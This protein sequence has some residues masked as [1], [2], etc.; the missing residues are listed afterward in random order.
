MTEN[1]NPSTSENTDN[2]T[3][4]LPDPANSPFFRGDPSAR[5]LNLPEGDTSAPRLL[6]ESRF[7]RED[8][9][10]REAAFASLDD[11]VLRPPVEPIDLSSA[12]EPIPSPEPDPVPA[13]PVN[14]THPYWRLIGIAATL[15]I[16]IAVTARAFESRKSNVGLFGIPPAVERTVTKEE[17]DTTSVPDLIVDEMPSEVS[18]KPESDSNSNT[19]E[20]SGSDSYGV[21][22]LEPNYRS[23]YGN[24]ETG[25]EEDPYQDGSGSSSDSSSGSDAYSDDWYGDWPNGWA[26]DLYT[27]EDPSSSANSITLPFDDG[28]ITYYYDDG[29][30]DI[31]AD[32]LEWLIDEGWI[33][34]GL[35]WDSFLDWGYGEDGYGYGDSYGY[36]SGQGYGG[37]GYGYG[38]PD[39]YGAGRSHRR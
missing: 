18:P 25:Y 29:T 32:V 6:T 13:Q 30:L 38:A 35:G 10:G 24:T 23:P 27:D 14:F 36:G 7:V 3:P 20:D 28:T 11:T 16:A 1:T 31:N 21:T 9:Q 4:L 15:V 12:A 33:D 26:D 22:G 39:G 37:Q 5:L 17:K 8:R 2:H 34:W 19:T